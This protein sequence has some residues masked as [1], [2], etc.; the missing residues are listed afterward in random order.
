MSFD[1][2]DDFFVTLSKQIPIKHL[3]PF[4]CAGLGFS[5]LRREFSHVFSVLRKFYDRYTCSADM[6]VISF[7]TEKKM[8][9]TE[10]MR[11]RNSRS[12]F[13]GG[14]LWDFLIDS[15]CRR[16]WTNSWQMLISITVMWNY[17]RLLD[18]SSLEQQSCPPAPVGPKSAQ[19]DSSF[20]SGHSDEDNS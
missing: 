8:Q 20:F 7:L 4:A 17:G 13:Y 10:K 5:L 6:L 15:R 11:G 2:E 18:V 16:K 1:S 3:W 19:I 12:S 14:N 9:G